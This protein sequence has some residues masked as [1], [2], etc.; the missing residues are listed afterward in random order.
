[1]LQ[2]P[3]A[4]AGM[5]RLYLSQ[6]LPEACDGSDIDDPVM[7]AW[8]S[9]HLQAGARVLD[10]GCGL[11]FDVLA[12]HRGLPARRAGRSFEVYGTDYSCDMLQDARR[13]GMTAGIPSDRYRQSSFAGLRDVPAWSLAMDAVTVNYAIYTQPEEGTDYSAYLADSLRGLAAVIKPGGFLAI[14]LRDWE[15]LKGAEA[16]GAAHAYSNTHGAQAFHCRYAWCFGAGRTHRTTLTMWEDGGAS[17][18]TTIWFAERSPDEIG[19]ALAAAGLH[20]VVAGRHGEGANSFHTLI[21]R[22]DVA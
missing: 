13:L 19:E 10:A 6:H 16:T 7:S 20:V 5:N 4:Y 8:L 12:L 1:M 9:A 18:Q 21:A 14:N 2:H 11:G 22:K 17:K 3:D 15:A